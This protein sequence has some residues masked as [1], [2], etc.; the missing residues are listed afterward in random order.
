[1][2][3]VFDRGLSCAGHPACTPVTIALAVALC[4]AVSQPSAAQ[5]SPVDLMDVSLTELLAMVTPPT[6]DEADSSS[7]RFSYRYV[8]GDFGGYRDGTGP[9]DNVDLMG[10]P[11]NATYPIL[12][13]AIVQEV[14][15]FQVAYNVSRRLSANVVVPYIRQL[16]DHISLVPGFADFTITSKGVGDSSVTLSGIVYQRGGDSLMINGGISVPTGSITEK[17]HTPAGPGSQLPYTMQ[18]GSGTWDIPVGV[19]YRRETNRGTGVGP[20]RYRLGAMG[21]VRS[22]ENSRGY[23]LGH[24]LVVD[25]SMSMQPLRW[26]SPSLGLSSETWGDIKGHDLNFPGPIYPTPVANPD[27]FGGQRVSVT[28]GLTFGTSQGDL[29]GHSLQM[30]FAVPVYQDLHGPQPEE[31]WRGNI[32]WNLSF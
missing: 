29:G 11:N 20:V 10:P 22:G 13:T 19:H 5:T 25:G 4:L 27:L 7:W 14:H 3:H 26:I 28:I 24:R 30:N 32:S 18:L 12:Q 1:M 2:R 6:D 23:R 31:N 16:T 15:L 8:R 17:G 9:V 21:K